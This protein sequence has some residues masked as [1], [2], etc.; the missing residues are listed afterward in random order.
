MADYSRQVNA[1]I[2]FTDE[3]TGN[4]TSF[5]WDFGDGTPIVT[6]V[7]KTA[8]HTYTTIGTFIITH[9]VTNMCYTKSCARTIEVKTAPANIVTTAITPSATTCTAPCNMTVGITW[10]NN[11]G[12]SGTFVPTM[13]VNGTST[14]LPEESLDPSLS[15]TK[16]FT[17]TGLVVGTHVICSKPNTFPC[18]IITVEQVAQAGFG[19]AG[20]VLI[21]GL[22]VGALYATTKKQKTEK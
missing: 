11:G 22:V 4:P 12:T 21:A 8:A 15:V 17:L 18:T 10:A 16:T 2:T 1:E 5:G 6:V 14:T 3:S 13:T 9:T 19:G 7:Q 20:M